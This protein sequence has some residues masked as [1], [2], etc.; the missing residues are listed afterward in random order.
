MK[1]ALW[2]ILAAFFHGLAGCFAHQGSGEPMDAA[3]PPEQSGERGARSLG[4]SRWTKEF[5]CFVSSIEFTMALAWKY[6]F[7]NEQ[8]NCQ[9][10]FPKVS[11]LCRAGTFDLSEAYRSIARSMPRSI[12]P[13]HASKAYQNTPTRERQKI[14]GPDTP[15]V[16]NL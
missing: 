7:K 13:K 14:I 16:D 9:R 11:S 15:H 4:G 6:P 5:D 3:E 10:L 12:P 2:W 8:P 1:L